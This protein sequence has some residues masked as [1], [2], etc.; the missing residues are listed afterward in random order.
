MNGKIF[1]PLSLRTKIAEIQHPAYLSVEFIAVDGIDEEKSSIY[2]RLD[3]GKM[4]YIYNKD[5]L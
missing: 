3:F 4:V 2:M 1:E 5:R